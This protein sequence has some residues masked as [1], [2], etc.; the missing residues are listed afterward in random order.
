M[1]RYIALRLLLM[2]LTF[3]LALLVLFVVL[4]IAPGRTSEGEGSSEAQRESDRVFREQFSLD[5]PLLFS[6][7]AWT[8]AAD[9]R[10]L[11][12][13]M[14]ASDP[15]R[16]DRA[17]QAFDDLGAY[18]L[19]PLTELVPEPDAVFWLANL[20]KRSA[21]PPP[22]TW[23]S[24]F[25]DT[26]LAK[27][28]E[29]VLTLDFGRSFVDR[30][31]VLPAI[32]AR[33]RISVVLGLMSILLAYALAIPI[34]VLGAAQPG[35]PFDLVTTTV[36][37]ALNAAPT[38]FVGTLLLELFA[39]GRP[40]R[41]FPASG[42]VTL[43]V[44][45]QTTI[46]VLRDVT[47]HLVLPV[48]TYGA[49]TLAALSRYARAGVIDVIRADH[50][51]TARAK[52]LPE[53]VVLVK[54]VA[55]NGMIPLLTLLGGLLPALVSGSVV[56]EVVFGIPGVGSY[57]YDAINLRDFNAVMGVLVIVTA[58]TIIGVFLSDIAVALAD[59]RVRLGAR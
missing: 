2:P 28:A 30:T 32:L 21:I 40:W 38:F 20:S 54:H 56:I 46:D 34:G 3:A 43:G 19:L 48:A 42:F 58:A 37:F 50:V 11:L 26:R 10:A 45:P 51:R 23:S 6:T 17:A 4:N 25:L 31:P 7:R 16:R 59:P 39:G 41:L 35:K 13:G 1:G 49:A 52:G 33:L 57:L 15:K 24:F 29:N 14:R 44:G 27:F 47:W 9:V 53:V 5:R 8:D 22:P 36:L 18:A 55:R 12:D